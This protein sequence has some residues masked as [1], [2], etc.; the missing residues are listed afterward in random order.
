MDFADLLPLLMFAALALLLFS[1]FPVAFIL[2]GVGLLFGMI[3]M[4]FDVFS[5]SEFGAIPARIYGSLAESLILTAIPMFILMGLVLERSGVARNLLDGLQYLM[6]RTPGALALAV[7]L[8]GTIMAATTGIIGASVVM[9]TVMALPL[10]ADQDYDMKFAGGT[11]AAAGTLGILLPPSIMLIIMAELLSKSVGV[12][13]KAAIVPGLIL[14]TFYVLYILLRAVFDPQA[15]PQRVVKTERLETPE[16][17]KL[18]MRSLLPPLLLIGLVLGSII[19][20]WATPTEAAGV[21]AA[22]ALLLSLF[23]RNQRAVSHAASSHAASCHADRQKEETWF[24]FLSDVLYRTA[25]TNAMLFAIFIGATIFAFTFRSLGGD[26]LITDFVEHLGLGPWGLLMMIMALVFLLG[27]FLDWIEITMIVL[28]VFAPIIEGFDFGT[29]VDAG[30]TAYWFAILLALN[31][32]TSFLTPPFGF[33]IFYMKAAA[34]DAIR[35]GQVYR[36]VIPYVIIQLIV[37]GLVMAFPQIA[38]WLPT[39]LAN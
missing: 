32:Q 3:G 25:T 31:L 39:Q 20:G 33:S 24:G 17:I 37:L 12:L 15:A 8:M 6:G 7:T 38:L 36:G 1:G 9:M 22:G 16:L 27:F 19:F 23:G 21:G 2:A 34:G 11:I 10:M 5:W 18:L 35:L 29:H 26:D 28:P 30:N 13:F 4:L 14:A